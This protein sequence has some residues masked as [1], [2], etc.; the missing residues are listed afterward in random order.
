M[1]LLVELKHKGMVLMIKQPLFETIKV[2]VPIVD[3]V[4]GM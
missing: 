3:A 4:A 2:T 1:K